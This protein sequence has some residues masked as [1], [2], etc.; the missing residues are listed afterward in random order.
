MVTGDY[1]YPDW[2]CNVDFFCNPGLRN[3]WHRLLGIEPTTSDLCS[4]SQVHMTSQP[5]R[6]SLI[7]NANNN[8]LLQKKL[9]A[10]FMNRYP[11]VMWR[12]SWFCNM[13]HLL[14]TKIDTQE[15]D[16]IFLITIL[17]RQA[18]NVEILT[19]ILI[20]SCSIDSGNVD[21]PNQHIYKSPA[22]VS[23]VTADNYYPDLVDYFA[24]Q[25]WKIAGIWPEVWT[26]DLRSWFSVRCLWPL[27]HGL[28]IKNKQ[29]EATSSNIGNLL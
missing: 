14:G 17:K 8:N 22:L 18:L 27:T 25:C 11:Y 12:I 3:C 26:H 24:I 5:R 10:L 20:F 23:M 1:Y 15:M 2:G 9:I 4:R 16:N 29:D 7:I 28:P 21:I 6:P 13:N 19:I